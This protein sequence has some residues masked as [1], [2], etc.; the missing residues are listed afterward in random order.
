MSVQ[1]PVL[2]GTETGNAEECAEQL[3]QSIS[4]LGWSSE[5]VD[6]DDFEP[7]DICDLPLVFIVSST[8]GN[9]DPP[10]NAEALMDYLQEEDVVLNNVHFAVCGLGDRAYPYFAQCGKDFDKY[11]EARGGTRLLQRTD[12]DEDFELPFSE[13]KGNVIAYLSS[14]KNLVNQ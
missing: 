1:I 6:L 11:M 10:E 12:C 9:G 8:H 13:F 2:Y 4:E 3:A 14:E 5:A 7:S